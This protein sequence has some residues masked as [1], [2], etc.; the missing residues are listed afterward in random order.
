MLLDIQVIELSQENTTV[1][2]PLKGININITV[3]ERACIIVSSSSP[4]SGHGRMTDTQPRTMS[5]EQQ[6]NGS[7][8]SAQAT[9]GPQLTVANLATHDRDTS[10]MTADHAVRSWLNSTG[11]PTGRHVDDETWAWLVR[12][13][14]LAADIEA[15]LRGG[16][17]NGGGQR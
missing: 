13:D 17:Q 10:M 3:L 1:Y 11:T 7:G 4:W 9:G 6:R 16:N 5:T 14:R 8:A 2:S 12:R 15:A